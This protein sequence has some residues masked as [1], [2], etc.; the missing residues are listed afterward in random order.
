MNSHISI[1]ENEFIIKVLLRREN[2]GL[3]DFLDEFYQTF[4]EQI[5]PTYTFF[6]KTK[7]KRILPKSI[8]PSLP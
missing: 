7:K 1:K 3:D 4:K 6:Q 8:R 5:I 2:A